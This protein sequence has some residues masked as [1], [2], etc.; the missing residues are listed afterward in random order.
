[1]F[2]PAVQS[3]PLK[4]MTPVPKAPSLLL[5]PKILGT[6]ETKINETIVTEGRYDRLIN[7]GNGERYFAVG[8]LMIDP[9]LTTVAFDI[10]PK[11]RELIGKLA[12][13]N[14]FSN[15]LKISAGSSSKIV[16]ELAK[17]RCF[18]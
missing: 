11:A 5:C 9:K 3:G 18:F 16:A 4:G 8:T 2:G 14:Y 15:R 7:I 12:T 17:P 13:F 1:V 10:L 6:Y